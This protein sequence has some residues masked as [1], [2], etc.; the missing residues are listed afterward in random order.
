MKDDD[1]TVLAKGWE[2]LSVACW[3]LLLTSRARNVLEAEI[4]AESFPMK[5]C[6][7]SSRSIS[8]TRNRRRGSSH[9]SP[10]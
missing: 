8:K 9:I 10:S 4:P 1:G 3:G 2:D 6:E 7:I 5:R